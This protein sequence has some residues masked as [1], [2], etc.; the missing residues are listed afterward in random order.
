MATGQSHEKTP[1][2]RLDP[3]QLV[4]FRGVVLQTRTDSLSA[5]EL[6]RVHS[7]VGEVPPVGPVTEKSS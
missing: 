1:R 3:A 5:A 6:G 4:G 2:V 7:K